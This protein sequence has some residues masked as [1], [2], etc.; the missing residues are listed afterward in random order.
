VFGETERAELYRSVAEEIVAAIREHLYSEKYERFLRS[1]LAG[2]N[3]E[4][5]ADNTVDAS[6][7]GIFYFD[8]FDVHDIAVTNTM[9]AVAEKL[10]NDGGIARFENDG[11]MRS[12]DTGLGNSWFISTLWLAEYYIAKA[13][14]FADLDPAM[15]LIEWCADRALASGVLSEQ[16]D[17]VIGKQSSVSPLTWSHSTFVSTVLSFQQKATFLHG[18]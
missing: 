17:S 12:G 1:L 6:L 4:L 7:F 3:D 10:K 15:K 18:A 13:K 5:Y 14:V 9:S 16:F 2:D 8:C 11:Y